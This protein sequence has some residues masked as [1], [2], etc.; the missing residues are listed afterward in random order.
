[1]IAGNLRSSAFALGMLFLIST[2]ALAADGSRKAY[3][4][5]QELFDLYESMYSG[6]HNIHVSYSA[7]LETV[8]GDSPQLQQY[9]K[10]DTTETIELEGCDK[11]YVRTTA[12]P[13]G[14]TDSAIVYESAF[15]GFA[16]SRYNPVAG[17]KTGSIFWRKIRPELT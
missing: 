1:M 11:Y 16:T 2:S 12:D 6:M 13:N 10:Y 5:A 3:L 14:F 7:M 4:N 9:T 15:D 17:S 8:I